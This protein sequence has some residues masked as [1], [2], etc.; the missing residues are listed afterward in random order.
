MCDR[1]AVQSLP[2]G[3]AAIPDVPHPAHP[4]SDPQQKIQTAE[5]IRIAIVTIAAGLVWFHLLEPVPHVSIIGIAAV[6]VGGY[7]IFSEACH[8]VRARRMTMELSMTIA[9]LA[10]LSI[11]E[12]FT[13]LVITLFVL[14]AEV[15]ERHTVSRGRIAIDDLLRL[16]PRSAF[17]VK[18]DKIEE[19]PISGIRPGD[20]ILV[21]PGAQIPVDGIVESGNSAVDEATITGEAA[22]V[23]KAPGLKVFAGTTNQTGA[24]QVLVE[25]LGLDTTFGRIVQAV[26]VAE[27]S[28]APVQRLADRLAGYL[29]YFALGSA[30]VTLVFTHDLRATLSVI[31][32]AGAC[33]I[34]AGTPLAILGA[35][36]SAAHA[37]GVIKG[38]LYLELLAKVDTILLDKTGTLT[39]G[40]PKVISVE[41]AFGVEKGTL[42]QIAAV[43]ERHSEHPIA[44]AILSAALENGLPVSESTAFRYLPGKGV[45]VEWIGSKILAGNCAWLKASGVFVPIL[46][47]VPGTHVAIARDGKFLGIV[48]LADEVRKEAARAV[49]R[50]Q[51]LKIDVKLLTGDSAGPAHDV[52]KSIGVKDVACGLLPQE[53]FEHVDRLVRSG[54][55][56]AMIGDGINDAPALARAQIGVAMGSGTELAQ[57][58]A[59]ILLIGN[60]LCKF[61]HIIQIARHCRSVILQNFYGTLLVDAVGM[62]L[63]GFGLIHPLMAAFIHVSSELLF[64]LNSTRLLPNRAHSHIRLAGLPGAENSLAASVR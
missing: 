60:D 23:E 13:A 3:S 10:A 34:A 11:G 14:I 17:R 37:G 58:T 27:Q 62:V 35:I 12:F 18:D 57:S 39:Y 38:G 1:S 36:A 47:E 33:G 59:N 54:R 41:P 24:I 7:P 16:L 48:Y 4:P 22:P 42:L 45:A 6:L 21:R 55:V 63:A 20:R 5:Q 31:I 8:D 61:M 49:E 9:L 32:V 44:K 51:E 26:E 56:V 64:I 52:A 28:R 19:L 46:D 30:L 15:L 50:M 53:K 25:R 2:L 43:A 40:K 29:V